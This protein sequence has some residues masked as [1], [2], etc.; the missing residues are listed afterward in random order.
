MSPRIPLALGLLLAGCTAPSG[1]AVP[2]SHPGVAAAPSSPALLAAGPLA[3]AP[4]PDLPPTLRPSAHDPARHAPGA[5]RDDALRPVLDAYLAVHD[6]LAEDRFEA[7]AAADLAARLGAWT[8][9]PPADDPHLWH[10]HASDVEATLAAAA[11]L[12]GASGLEAARAA[13][14]ALSAPF[15]RLVEAAG[16]PVGLDLE[17]FRCGMA[18]VAAGGVWLQPAGDAANPYFGPSMRTCGT[19]DAAPPDAGPARH[20]GAAPDEAHPGTHR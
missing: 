1:V 2:D 9:T 12:A 15:V 19:R 20:D 7:R 8:T 18:D 16:V 17:R 4:E 13:F 11:D 14:G 3:P 5:S 10:R 6:A